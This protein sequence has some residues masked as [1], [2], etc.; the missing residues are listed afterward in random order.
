[1][2]VRGEIGEIGTIEKIAG[3][4]VEGIWLL[5]MHSSRTIMQKISCNNLVVSCRAHQTQR[6]KK[7][8]ICSAF[9]HLNFEVLDVL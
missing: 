2:V 1:M 7:I 4:I 3:S 9:I 8:L 5:G 6:N